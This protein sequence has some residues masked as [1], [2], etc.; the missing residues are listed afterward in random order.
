MFPDDLHAELIR[1]ENGTL[2]RTDASFRPRW[3]ILAASALVVAT[4]TLCVAWVV[5]RHF[6]MRSV[7]ERAFLGQVELALRNYAQEH[8]A[9]PEIRSRGGPADVSWRVLVLPYFESRERALFNRYNF[10]SAWNSGAN[11]VMSE[12]EIAPEYYL[13]SSTLAGSNERAYST[14]VIALSDD[15]VEIA[16]QNGWHVHELRFGNSRFRMAIVL[17]SELH[18]MNPGD[19]DYIKSRSDIEFPNCF[20]S[21]PAEPVFRWPGNACPSLQ[22]EWPELAQ[23]VTRPLAGHFR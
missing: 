23:H 8:G 5:T 6:D 17:D 9:F 18:W 19:S 11:R 7:R 4:L 1:R 10:S 3:L 14:D 15:Q 2:V 21:T 20:S 13:S 16:E 12:T 22:I